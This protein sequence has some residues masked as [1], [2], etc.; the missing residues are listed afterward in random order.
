MASFIN[1][2]DVL[3]IWKNVYNYYNEN[4]SFLSL[5]ER[6]EKS[7]NIA[8]R[9]SEKNLSSLIGILSHT[10][11]S[12]IQRY[13]AC[14]YAYFMDYILKVNKPKD[15]VVDSIDIGNVS[16][17]ILE[18]LCKE[19]SASGTPFKDVDDDKIAKRID[20]MLGEYIENMSSLSDDFSKR[21]RFIIER[22]KGSILLCFKAVKKHISESKFEP[23]GYEMEFSE[24][25]DLGTIKI[26]T[27]D[28]KTVNIT[29]KID[30]ADAY[31]TENGTFI[32]VIDYKTG[33]KTFRLDEVF[34]GLDVQLIVYMNALVNSNP[35]YN[36][37]GALYFL[38]SDPVIKEDKHISE[39]KVKELLDSALEFKGITVDD[40]VVRA[41]YDSKT[42]GINNKFDL[43]KFEVMDKYL[44]KLL[45]RICTDMTRG[46]ISINPYKKG[47]FSPCSY[48]KYA[49]VCRFDPSDKNN[50][51]NH[52]EDVSKA[53]EIFARMEEQ[54]NVD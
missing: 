50:S 14:H 44:K 20:E 49:S 33:N 43:H 7:D 27:E 13:T 52:L 3:P 32:R 45:G 18:M 25:S 15:E 23:L 37:G 34:Y 4:T 53:N 41:G 26:K 1:G 39:D 9:L 35:S 47:S 51:Y 21:D 24:G 10:S 40:E 11:V 31:K 6:F 42:N 17:G 38:I 5:A 46:D 12:K 29:G 36:Y 8:H 19:I 48:C 22:L 28:G 54:V 30:R 16:H 2:D